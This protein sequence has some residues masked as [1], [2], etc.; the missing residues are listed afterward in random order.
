MLEII[1]MIGVLSGMSDENF[2]N[3]L[4]SSEYQSLSDRGKIFFKELAR[5]ARFRR[6][7]SRK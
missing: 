3:I 2:N 5:V 7:R 6:E 4:S 1:E